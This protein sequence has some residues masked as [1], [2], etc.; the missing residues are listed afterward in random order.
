MNAQKADIRPDWT[1]HWEGA[2]V[3]PAAAPGS[4]P[5]PAASAEGSAAGTSKQL[6]FLGP[7]EG[8]LHGPA[9]APPKPLGAAARHRRKCVC[10]HTLL[11]REVGLR[12]SSL[13]FRHNFSMKLKML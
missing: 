4:S 2:G 3:P 13:Y 11:L 12:G 9:S 7:L 1:G 8:D 6:L 5:V 10:E